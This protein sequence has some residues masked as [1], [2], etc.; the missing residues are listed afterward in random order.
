MR[1]VKRFLLIL[2]VSF[3]IPQLLL[4]LVIVVTTSCSS[5]D[6][7][8]FGNEMADGISRAPQNYADARYGK[9]GGDSKETTCRTESDGF[10]GY[11]TRCEEE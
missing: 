4:F 1:L 7:R 6:L 3:N 5:A 8:E 10:G 9:S 2:A 11:V